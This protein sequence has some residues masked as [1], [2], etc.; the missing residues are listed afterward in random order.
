MPEDYQNPAD[1][2]HSELDR[3]FRH[4]ASNGDYRYGD[5]LRKNEMGQG[6]VSPNKL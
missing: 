3:W 5:G 4:Y 1:F 6:T 2:A